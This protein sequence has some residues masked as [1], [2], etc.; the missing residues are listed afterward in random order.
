MDKLKIY[1]TCWGGYAI[2][3]Y[4]QDLYKAL[5]STTDVE[6]ITGDVPTYKGMQV[7][8]LDGSA[9]IV[10]NLNGKFLIFDW[11]D[12]FGQNGGTVGLT[13]HEDCLGYF[14]SQPSQELQDLSTAIPHLEFKY[15]AFN[16]RY[17]NHYKKSFDTLEDV[18]YFNGEIT[19]IRINNNKFLKNKTY[20]KHP[21]FKVIQKTDFN[22]YLQDIFKYKIIYSPAGGGDFTHRDFETFALGIPVIRQK[23]ISTTTTLQAGVHYIDVDCIEDYKQ[24]LDNK[25]LLCTIGANGRIWYEQNCLYPGNVERIKQLIKDFLI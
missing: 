6:L 25:E 24:L 20:E 5:I 7:G 17:T 2:H 19:D 16:K 14:N 18:I 1:N 11:N 3:H 22:I 4:A 9:I 12:Q 13:L 15:E 8:N 21:E 10:E 23:Y